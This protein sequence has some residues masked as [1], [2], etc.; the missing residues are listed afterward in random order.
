MQERRTLE[1]KRPKRLQSSRCCRED[2]EEAVDGAFLAAAG[3]GHE[4]APRP[5]S[6]ERP[7]NQG[8]S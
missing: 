2:A 6:E 3:F 1:P 7:R 5:G 8:S 4:Q